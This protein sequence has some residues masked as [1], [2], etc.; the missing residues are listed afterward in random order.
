VGGGAGRRPAGLSLDQPAEEHLAERVGALDAAWRLMAERLEEA[1]QVA[2]LSF[3][4]QGY[5]RLK[6][7]VDRLGALG[8]PKSLR[9]LRRTTGAMLPA[10]DLPDL[11]FEGDSCTGFLERPYGAARATPCASA[12][13]PPCTASSSP[14]ASRSTAAR[15]SRRSRPS[16]RPAASTRTAS[17]PSEPRPERDHRLTGSHQP[18]GT[19]LGTFR[20]V[21]ERT[22]SWLHGFRRL[23]I[24]WERRDDIHE[25]FLG[26]A[27]C[28]ITHRHVQ[29][30][31]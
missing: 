31:S 10:D 21:V 7:H 11:L 9:W 28:L 23:R 3:E 27:V 22:I 2:K 4:V 17:P 14:A 12:P 5:G 30:L 15:A 20:W 24:R 26:L 29:R 19:G 13:S 18:H 1:G 25:A 8:E 16:A 6:L